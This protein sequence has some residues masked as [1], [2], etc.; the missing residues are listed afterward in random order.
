MPNNTITTSIMY[1]VVTVHTKERSVLKNCLPAR[2][3]RDF[4]LA[5]IAYSFSAEQ[6]EEETECPLQKKKKNKELVV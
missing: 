2:R 5:Y 3:T 1:Y 6:I 4:L